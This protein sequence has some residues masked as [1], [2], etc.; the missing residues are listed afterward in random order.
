MLNKRFGSSNVLALN[1]RMWREEQTKQTR[2]ESLLLLV[3]AK[4]PKTKKEEKLPLQKI[5]EK[6]TLFIISLELRIYEII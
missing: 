2:Q 1:F 4:I 5:F 3:A 6:E